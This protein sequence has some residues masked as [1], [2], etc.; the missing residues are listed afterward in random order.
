MTKNSMYTL[1]QA[2]QL[3][4]DELVKLDLTKKP[5]VYR[6]EI[7]IKPVDQIVWLASQHQ[8]IKIYGANQ[9]NSASIAGIGS[10]MSLSG[11][12]RVDVKTVMPELRAHLS[13]DYP[14]MQWYGGF[15]FDGQ[16]PAKMWPGFGTYRFVLPQVELARD[17]SKM[18]LALNLIGTINKKFLLKQIKDLKSIKPLEDLSITK[19]KTRVDTPNKDR[20]RL[21][22]AKVLEFISAEKCQKVVLARKTNFDFNKNINP[23]SL[24]ARLVKETPRS[25]HFAFQFGQHIFLGASP[26]R[27][28][29][30]QGNQIVSQALA[31]TLNVAS[32]PKQLL[33]SGKD[34]WEHQLVVDA[35]KKA[36]KPLTSK[37]TCAKSPSIVTLTNGHHLNTLFQGQ[38]KKDVLDEHILEALHPTP[39]LGGEP[40]EIALQCIRQMEGFGRSWYG[41]P[42]GYIGLHTAEFV[43][44]IRSGLIKGKS[45]SVFAGAGIVE[46]STADGEWNEIEHKISNFYKIIS[47]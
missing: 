16:S 26:E 20:W 33:A 34:R 45:L 21:N 31:G 32:S 38:L 30:R 27:L 37:L 6:I 42:V 43:V 19:V 3:L 1:E 40:R 2:Q 8:T 7:K 9:D 25:Y 18:L 41:G 44:A 47:R 39:A 5:H 36:L 13:N 15:T 24:L 10:A 28:Y 22:V 17:G 29:A 14:H 35:I 46:G 11:H 23:W 4:I 12:G